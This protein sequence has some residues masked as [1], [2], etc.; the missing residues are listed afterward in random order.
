[1]ELPNSL[2]PPYYPNEKIN[3]TEC[4]KIEEECENISDKQDNDD[5]TTLVICTNE[6]ESVLNPSMSSTIKELKDMC[7]EKGLSTSGKKSDLI[8]RL[9]A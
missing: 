6:S 3:S 8:A 4:A 1:M 9:K 2:I 7:K 5:D